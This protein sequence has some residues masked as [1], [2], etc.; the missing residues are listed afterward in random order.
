MLAI[1]VVFG[2]LYCLIF[3]NKISYS[4]HSY[5]LVIFISRCFAI[6][7][8]VAAVKLNIFL[9]NIAAY[10]V[11]SCMGTTNILLPPGESHLHS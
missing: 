1:S 2:E 9:L 6:N 11:E 8:E 4:F 10:S 5:A 7:R 3:S